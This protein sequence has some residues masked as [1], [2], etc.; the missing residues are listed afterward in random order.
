MKTRV[1]ITLALVAASFSACG[2]SANQVGRKD[3]GQIANLLTQIGPYV[4]N[5]MQKTGVPG[6][7]VAVVYRDKVVYLEGFG[8]RRAGEAEP[9]D[10]NTVFQLASVSKPIASTVVASLVGDRQISWDDKIADLD[11]DFRLSDASASQQ[12]TIRDLLSHRSGLPT[13]A[14]DALEDL[15]FARPFILH[16]MRLLPLAGT[17]RNSYHYSNFGYTEGAIAAAKAA[18]MQWEDLAYK[19]LFQPVGMDS[20][21]YRYSDYEN[22]ANKAAI[23]VIIDGKAVARYHRDPDAE[24]PAGAAS[25]SVRDLAQWLRLQLAGGVWNGQT[26]VESNALNET[27]LPQIQSGTNR[28]TGKPTY[29]GLGW[30]V[31][32][33]ADGEV[34]LGHSGAFFL[35]TGTTVRFSPSKQLGIIVLTN[36]QPTGLAE[37]T[38]FT[39]FDN[40]SF[41]ES[42]RDWLT[43]FSGGFKAMIENSN[44]E[45]T[46]YSKL[47]PP[48]SPAPSKSLSAYAGTY[49]NEY[50]GGI[51]VTEQ[52]GSLWM[53]FPDTGRLYSLT[54]WD[55]DKFN[56]RFEEEQGIGTRGV[57][58][59]LTGA[60]T[61]T[62]EN[63]ALEGSGEFARCAH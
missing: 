17:F 53:R 26:I 32:Y 8:V 22:R 33:D 52:G 59:G 16:R 7:A 23:H 24:A 4:R 1:K 44:N 13:S 47:T 39:F 14:G 50:Y 35:G 41:G 63:L 37:A 18:R 57:S 10:R 48:S 30:D 12:L 45:T 49:C 15:G 6:V 28:D 5:G 11:R 62:I 40:Y 9:I 36:A 31:G 60:G 51:E 2:E 20:S 21:S 61:M 42:T 55:G 58:F 43:L 38:A 56:Y 3:N 34:V 29:Y 19:R 25:S 54:H 27:H 46:D